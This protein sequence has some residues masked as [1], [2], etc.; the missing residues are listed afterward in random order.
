MTHKRW[1]FRKTGWYVGLGMALL[2]TWSLI[3]GSFPF[4]VALAARKI[5][6]DFP[7][8]WWA[9]PG[10]LEW[11]NRTKEIV[12]KENPN[13]EIMAT[14]VPE[15]ELYDKLYMRVVAGNPPDIVY[16]ETPHLLKY[17]E[18]GVLEPVDKWLDEA[19]IDRDSFVP[20]WE[21]LMKDDKT[22]GIVATMNT[23]SFIYNTEM[24]E[25]AGVDVPANPWDFVT[26]MAKLSDP[27]KRIYG[28][29][30][31]LTT[32][33]PIESYQTIC[34]IMRGLGGWTATREGDITIT[35]PP[36]VLALQMIKAFSD[37]GY[38][39][40]GT[41]GS[42]MRKMFW[43]EKVSSLISGGWFFGFTK[44]AGYPELYEK[45]NAVEPP[46]PYPTITVNNYLTIPKDAKHKEAA[47]KFLLTMLRPE[48]QKMIV[49]ISNAPPGLRVDRSDPDIRD[50]LRDYPW[51]ESFLATAETAQPRVP[52]GF[53][54]KGPEAIKIIMHHVLNVIFAD[55]PIESE[56]EEARKELEKL[57]KEM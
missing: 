25:K 15:V 54:K 45:L 46:F 20:A 38:A 30:F 35:E 26:A 57:Q 32:A 11:M 19:K 39:P 55:A 34:P 28:Y 53:E 48:I 17:L 8:H 9:E 18:M 44:S 49:T 24:Y 41:P 52:R 42:T 33:N 51:F 27:E 2:V 43:E 21:Y 5:Q 47:A 6:V 31:I 50:F 1:L 16:G 36:I 4:S 10:A 40:R 22:Y 14:M 29:G 12:E 56:L 23:R 3:C 37:R 7:I 13:I